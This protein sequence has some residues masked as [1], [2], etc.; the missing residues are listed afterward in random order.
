MKED[1]VKLRL[2]ALIIKREEAVIA[3]RKAK[4]AVA[5]AHALFV[6][7]GLKSGVLT[8]KDLGAY[9]W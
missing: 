3:Y 2:D 4:V 7:E 5:E 9:C 6:R 1:Q 8:P